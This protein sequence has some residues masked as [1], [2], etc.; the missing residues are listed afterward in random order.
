M[1][2]HDRSS[3]Q[4][5][6]ALAEQ[7]PSTDDSTLE[8]IKNSGRQFVVVVVDGAPRAPPRDYLIDCTMPASGKIETPAKP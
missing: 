2:A 7:G 5:N 6:F 4:P 3:V 8:R 1:S